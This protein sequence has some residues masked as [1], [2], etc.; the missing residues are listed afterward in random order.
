MCFILS[1]I[2]ASFTVCTV[3]REVVSSQWLGQV[4]VSPV[5]SRLV[6]GVSPVACGKSWLALIGSTFNRLT[7]CRYFST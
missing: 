3:V 1:A 5:A 2:Q 4:R 6:I 7:G